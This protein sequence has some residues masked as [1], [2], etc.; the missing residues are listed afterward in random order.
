MR[1]LNLCLHCGANEADWD[2]IKDV[3]TP[4]AT[5]TWQPIP[6]HTLVEIV[7][8][9]LARNGLKVVDQVHALWQ[10][11]DRYFGALQLAGDGAR[12]MEDYALVAGIRN[13]HDKMFP[14]GLACGSRVFIC[15]NLAFSGEVQLARKHTARVMEDLPR[16]INT[17]VGRLGGMRINQDKR[18][19]AY[20]DKS[21]TDIQAHDVLVRAVDSKALPI[22][23]LPAVLNEWRDSKHEEF[24][25][26][27]AWSLFNSFTEIY[28]GTT[29]ITLSART[30]PLHGLFDQLCGLRIEEEK[31]EDATIVGGN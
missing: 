29:P 4:D 21:V 14:V 10:G 28:K 11:G 8:E 15:D 19:A 6:H 1:R 31:F 24:K 25:P 12:E 18:I 2:R 17:A 30:I 22:T 16:L 13:S 5:D 20:K 27:T 3:K 23:K 26:R 7:T 9:T